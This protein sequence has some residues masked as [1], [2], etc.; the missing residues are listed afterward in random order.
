M[1]RT[2]WAVFLGTRQSRHVECPAHAITRDSTG[3]DAHVSN[4]HRIFPDTTDTNPNSKTMT[5]QLNAG[6]AAGA[7]VPRELCN[8]MYA[9][10]Y[11]EEGDSFG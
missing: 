4:G 10:L 11:D 3:R 5:R 7:N 9:V 1:G 2:C 8:N 6:S